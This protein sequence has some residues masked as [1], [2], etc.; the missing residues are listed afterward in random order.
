MTVHYPQSELNGDDPGHAWSDAI[1]PGDRLPDCDVTDLT[2]GNSVKLLSTERGTAHWLLVMPSAD[3]MQC[4]EMLVAQAQSAAAPYGDLIQTVTILPSAQV[5]KLPV[6]CDRILIDETGELRT[7]LGLSKSA[8]ALVRPDGYL[9]FR[10]NAASKPALE[11]HL[12][13]YLVSTAKVADRTKPTLV[14]SRQ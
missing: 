1:K 7:L 5:A 14:G 11:K 2:T 4:A 3:E 8:L 6:E 13:T 9:G 12:A 10:G